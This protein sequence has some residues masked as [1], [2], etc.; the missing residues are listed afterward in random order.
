MTVYYDK[1]ICIRIRIYF[2]KMKCFVLNTCSNNDQGWKKPLFGCR[3]VVYSF[4]AKNHQKTT[5]KPLCFLLDLFFG[6]YA[7]V[8]SNCAV[9][10][11]WYTM[12]MMILP[13]PT[14]QKMVIMQIIKKITMRFAF[15]L[16]PPGEAE[17]K[18]TKYSFQD[19]AG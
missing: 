1:L 17:K 11:V 16:T 4:T 9:V 6:F 3:K 19:N 10:I 18:G 13:P 14:M 8:M 15:A 2:V 5:K 12:M 7:I